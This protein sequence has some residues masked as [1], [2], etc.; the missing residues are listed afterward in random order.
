MKRIPRQ[1]PLTRRTGSGGAAAIHDAPDTWLDAGIDAR[2]A[3]DA[4]ALLERLRRERD[5]RIERGLLSEASG[6]DLAMRLIC[7]A[8]HTA[9]NGAADP[10]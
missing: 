10:P 1:V 5:L 8:A 2:L 3:P 4:A 9:P 6:I 7:E